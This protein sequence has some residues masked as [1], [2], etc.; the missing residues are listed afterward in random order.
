MIFLMTALSKR[1]LLF[2]L[3]LE[4]GSYKLEQFSFN[5]EVLDCTFDCAEVKIVN[6]QIYFSF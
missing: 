1:H 6:D 4:G 3:L 2:L 5:V